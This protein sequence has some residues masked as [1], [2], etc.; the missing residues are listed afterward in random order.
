MNDRA[1]I[2]IEY[3]R[4]CQW[5]LRSTWYA[6]ELLT[7]F[8]EELES[9]SLIPTTGGVFQ[10]RCNGQLIWDRKT[11]AGFPDIKVLK[12]I[13]RDCIAPTKDLGHSERLEN[14]RQSQ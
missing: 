13:I 11:M 9:I 3:C 7:T 10:I 12:Q 1:K 4:Q 5:M 8:A 6:Q 14:Q 2:E